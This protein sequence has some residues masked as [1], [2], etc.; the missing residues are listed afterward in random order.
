MVTSPDPRAALGTMGAVG[1]GGDDGT[2]DLSASACFH[3]GRPLSAG[4]T[5]WVDI[6]AQPRPM[7]CPGCQAVAETI[8]ASGL[9]AYYRQRAALPEGPARPLDAPE[10]LSE[11]ALFESADDDAGLVTPLADGECE[12]A[13][14]LE[15]ITCAA[16]VWLIER[17]LAAE[18]GVSTVSAN[19]VTRRACVRWRPAETRLARVLAAIADIGYRA[20]PYSAE[21]AE[22]G[23]SRER[24]EALKRLAVAGLGMMQVM[25]YAVPAYLADAGDMTPDIAS[26]MRWASLLLTVPVIGYSAAPFFLGAMRDLR[27]RRLGMD[28]PV[29]LGL[30]AAFV[31]SVGATMR[32]QGEVYFDSVTMFVFL[33][34]T[35]RYLE[36]LARQ[37]ALRGIE[38]LAR[39]VPATALR[40]PDWP[41]RTMVS[42]PVASLAVGDRVLVQPGA[43]V[44][45]DGVL[46]EGQAQMDE[47]LLTGESRPVMRAPGDSLVGGSLNCASPI[48]FAVTRV[49]ADT[50]VAQIARLAERAQ[51]DKPRL[52]AAA[53][54]IAR[55]FIMAVLLLAGLTLVAWLWHAPEQALWVCVSVLVVSCPCA[56]SLAMPTALAVATG[57]LARI[58]LLVA[59]GQAIETLAQVRRMVFD[60][61]GTLTHG[62][63]QLISVDTFGRMT[64]ADALGHAAALESGSEHVL[65]RAL[66]AEGGTHALPAVAAIVAVPGQGVE[67][68]MEGWAGG[69]GGQRL[70]IGRPDYVRELSPAYASPP[71]PTAEA[72]SATLVDLGDES[73]L[74]ARFALADTLRPEAR[75]ALAG[76]R[77]QGVEITL[78]SGDGPAPVAA[79]AAEA[80][81]ADARAGLTPEG[82]RAA[83]MALQ[84]RG[85]VVAMVG[86]G[87]NDA[88]VLAQAQVSIAMGGGTDLAR[89]RGDL[90]LLHDDLRYITAAVRY[91]RRTL[92]V[93][94]QNLV[95]ALV[96]NLAAIPAAMLGWVTPWMAGIGMSASSLLVVLN[97]LRLQRVA[98]PGS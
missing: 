85:E 60:K 32:N 43:V 18:P 40:L 90:V 64:G 58:G 19:Y 47:S 30:G 4:R 33:L 27:R 21:S 35:G 73:G 25:M 54:R 52:V 81:I 79:V 75:A 8:V 71:L 20:H 28:V 17:R 69:G 94:R 50:R 24:R 55:H 57:G 42:V 15:G 95:W 66:R 3:C 97:A 10:L 13:L 6:D 93:A 16:C 36:L 12:A 29:A 11:L 72:G 63:P 22:R 76:L 5:W 39:A 80:G 84:A 62:R 96:Y 65:A 87:V 67:G 77:A 56:L 26:L 53:D 68:R 41:E 14:I 70:R 45:A 83:L 61:T 9:G 92:A 59:N 38:A 51:A 1:D 37:R 74:L 48:V 46:V 44:P 86:D 7:C 89:A 78:L 98:Q 49:G 23:A 91:A 2:T 31:A 34:L 88:P 82:K